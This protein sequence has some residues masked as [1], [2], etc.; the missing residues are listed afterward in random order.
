MA[1]SSSSTSSMKTEKKERKKGSTERQIPSAEPI[2]LEGF[3][4]KTM[5]LIELEKEAEMA[6]AQ[7]SLSTLKPEIA[8]KKGVSLLN[9]KCSD[10]QTGLFGKSLLELKPN[11]G[12]LLPPH[13]MTLH[14]VVVLKMNKGGGSSLGQGIV[15]RVKEGSITIAMEDVPDE[16]LNTPIRIEKLVNEVTYKRY[17]DT[18]LDLSKDIQRSPAADMIPVLFGAKAPA[19]A[20]KPMQFTPFNKDLNQ[21]QIAAIGKA[22]V[23]NNVMLLHG[24]PGTGKTVTIVEMILQE[25]KRGS[26]VLACAAS[27]IAVDNLVERLACHKV[28]MVRLGHPARL[29]PQVLDSA[30]DAKVMKAD[31]SALANDIRK[32][33]K[34]LNGQLLKAKDRK[35]RGDLR[36]ELRYLAK[37]EKNRQQDAVSDI[38]KE[39]A[40][41][42]TTLTGALSYHLKQTTFDVVVIDEAAQAL[43]VAC[44]IALLKGQRCILAG[45]HLQLPP[46]VLSVE[47]EKNGL[48][49]TLFGRLA[50]LYESQIVAMLTVQY[51]MNELIMGWSSGELY[52]NKLT[53]HE[54]VKDQTL[55]QLEGVQSSPAT[56]P[57]L[58]LIDTAGCDMDETKDEADSTS[59]EGEAKVALAHAKRLLQS[60]VKACDIGIIAPYNAQVGLL[61]SMRNEDRKLAELEISSVDGF[62]GREKEAI[63]ISMV[64]SNTKQEVGFL[65]DKRRMNVAV[66]RARRQ[67]CVVCDTETV[68][69]NPFLKRLVAYLEENGEY[70]SAQEYVD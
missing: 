69:S 9:L 49:I 7:S 63:I 14:D 21:S 43:E 59:N 58:I 26:R 60:G 27:N 70:L 46:T 54:S 32:E 3:V 22:L 53:A 67:C 28:Q 20:K 42:C 5:P 44:W 39:S 31:N 37:E 55:C 8:E 57:T 2:T 23:S 10:V 41:I 18:L 38:I 33:M 12:D 47:A 65:S 16:G 64:R 13:K 25:V 24:P 34:G 1:S 51:R 19:F 17:R 4:S 45:D 61:R 29:L 56:D 68:S 35:T 11:K 40:V 66:T 15:Y 48:G 50:A 30:L 62:Q 36:K 6:A 52:E